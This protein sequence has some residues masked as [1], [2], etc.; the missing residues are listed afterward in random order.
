MLTLPLDSAESSPSLTGGKA[1]NLSILLRGG[2]DVPSGFVVSTL[3]YQ[4]FVDKKLLS[5][6]EA[7]LASHEDDL[8]EASD[9]PGRVSETKALCYTSKRNCNAVI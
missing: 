4:N 2:I 1:H 8:D 5:K 9:Y 7:T 3:A 6:I